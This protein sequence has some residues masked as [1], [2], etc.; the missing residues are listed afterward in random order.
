MSPRAA[1]R[2]E[3]LGYRAYDY[4]DGIADWKAAGL[5]TEGT[6]QPGQRVADATNGDVPTCQPDET[7]E[8]IRARVTDG[9]WDVCVVIDCDGMAIGRIRASAFEADPDRRASEVMEP[10]PS[11]VRPDTLLQPLVH[12]MHNRNAPHVLVTTP[13]GKLI[14]ILLRDEADRLLAGEP[15]HRIWQDCECCPGRWTSAHSTREST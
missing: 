13:P 5:P 3:A 8:D 2:L 6:A 11:T 9:G 12:R 14:G 7:V 4:V 1:C 10:G 15:P